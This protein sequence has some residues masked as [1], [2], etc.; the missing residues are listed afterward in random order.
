MTLEPMTETS[1][2]CDFC[3]WKTTAM[4]EDVQEVDGGALGV[5]EHF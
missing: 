5:A 2:S 4:A 1:V 3:L